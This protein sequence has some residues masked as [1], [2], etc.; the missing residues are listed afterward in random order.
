M[1]DTGLIIFGGIFAFT[2][3]TFVLCGLAYFFYKFGV[4]LSEILPRKFTL[5][6][7]MGLMSVGFLP[8]AIVGFFIPVHPILQIGIFVAVLIFQLNPCAIGFWAGRH[9]REEEEQKRYKKN[10]DLWTSEWEC[11]DEEQF[12]A[13]NLDLRDLPPEG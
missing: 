6:A 10:V 5:R 8:T 1:N 12:S 9:F 2:L 11:K 7:A 3:G 4:R 13:D